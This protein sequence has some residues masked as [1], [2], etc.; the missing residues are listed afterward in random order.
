MTTSAGQLRH[1]KSERDRFVAFSFASADIL[2]E[3]SASGEILFIDGAINGLLGRKAEELH[4]TQMR[5]IVHPDDWGTLSSLLEAQ[6]DGERME[7]VH[8]RLTNPFGDALPFYMSGYRLPALGQHYFLT[9]IFA[10][11]EIAPEELTQRDMETGLF[12]ASGFSRKAVERIKENGTGKAEYHIALVDFPELKQFLD[13]LP[14]KSAQNLLYDIQHYLRQHSL[15][16]DTAGIVDDTAFS[17]VVD[18]HITQEQL[19]EELL[20]ITRQADPD[21]KGIHPTT[22]FIT[23]DFPNISE[24][25]CANALLYTINRF[26]RDE[27][28]S[29][30][31]A[32]LSQGYKTMLDDTVRKISEFKDTVEG[33]KF[34]LAFQ[35]IVDL[36]NGITHHF[37]VLVRFEGESSFANPFQFISFGEEAGII[38]EFDL[39]MCQRAI[40]VL[41]AARGEGRRPKVAVNLS[42]KSLSSSLY[43][44]ALRKLAGQAPGINKQLIFEIT[45]S[46]KITDM[47]AANDFV[48]ELRQQGFL[49]CLDD[50]GVGESSFSYLR[51]LQVDFVKIDGSYVKESLASKRGQH[52]LK[53]M[54]GMC[55]ELG[56]VTIGEMVEDEK[57]AALLW[58]NGVRFGQGY[59]FGKPTLDTDALLQCQDVN[60]YYHGIMRAK[61]FS[62]PKNYN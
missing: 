54:S 23:P 10:K 60:P 16:Q 29:F 24:Q 36:K 15:G 6:N 33:A 62:P 35:P 44:D 28:G 21:G 1:L 7:L 20:S 53:A 61:R 59:L 5:D 56:I 41:I 45:E 11:H 37:E 46:A 9:F 52:L 43:L 12:N 3:I 58:E 17:L 32:S 39:A 14:Q 49:C 47:E 31:I 55:R 4:H 51:S 38:G 50:F 2:V 25:D 30:N 40:D 27:G 42:G 26:A 19:M 8:I 13:A 57:V 22:R 48:Q 34:Q 18:S